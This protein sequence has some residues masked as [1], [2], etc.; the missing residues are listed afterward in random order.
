MRETVLCW[1]QRGMVPRAQSGCLVRL[2]PAMVY[3]SRMRGVV[4]SHE[5]QGQNLHASNQS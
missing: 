3:Q 5:E 1:R 2:S 4:R